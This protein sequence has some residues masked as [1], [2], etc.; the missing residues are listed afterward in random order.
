[1]RYAGFLNTFP[2]QIEFMNIK[3]AT[4]MFN[5]T[6]NTWAMKKFAFLHKWYNLGAVVTLLLCI[7]SMILLA[8]TAIVS[9][10]NLRQNNR[11]EEAALQPV[12]P[13]VNLPKSDLLYYFITLL[14][15]TV[16]HEMGHAVAA[17]K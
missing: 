14:I 5:K 11:Q 12:L 3:W 8:S 4:T 17:I 13:G 15:C 6:L 2:I 1:M 9:F 10:E 16:V 7:P